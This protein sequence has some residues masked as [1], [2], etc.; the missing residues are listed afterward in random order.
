MGELADVSGSA[1]SDD[2]VTHIE[3]VAAVGNPSRSTKGS[4]GGSAKHCFV[5]HSPG[6]TKA[7][8]KERFYTQRFLVDFESTNRGESVVALRN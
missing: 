2:R 6:S 5:A 4:H 3:S 1:K 8:R 7:A